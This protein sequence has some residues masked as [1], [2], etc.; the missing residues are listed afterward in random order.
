[1]MARI[2]IVDDEPQL[3][4]SLARA[5]SLEGHETGDA[6]DGRL[7]LAALDGGGYDLAIVDLSM[8]GMDGTEMLRR[9]VERGDKTPVIILTAHGTVERA[10]MALRNGA[11]DFLEKP[12]ARDRLVHAVER[13]LVHSR[14]SREVEDLRAEADTAGEMVGSGPLMDELR[15]RIRLAAPSDGRILITGENGTGKELVAHA[16]HRASP[17][18]ERPI[19]KVNCAAV[20]T[21]LFESELF[22]HVRGAFTDA[23]EN[24]PGCFERAH[25]GTLFLDEVGEVPLA[26][27]PKLLRAIEN[28]EIQRLGGRR[29]FRVDVRLVA[30]TNR[31]LEA[32][33]AAGRFRQDLFYRLNV[34][35]LHVPPLRDHPQDLP[36][37]A[38][39][40]LANCC[41]RNGY[42]G[43]ELTPGALARLGRHL[44]P[45]NVRELR[46]AMERLAILVP[47]RQIGL[48]DV[49]RILPEVMHGGAVS[50]SDDGTLRTKMA[51]AERELLAATLA[52]H[53]WR[54]AAAARELGMERSHLYKKVRAH[55]LKK[56]GD[57][58]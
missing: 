49:E 6:T 3:R 29:E 14:L 20:P 12:P 4:V 13:A 57:S 32:D 34:I 10:V 21:S 5:L 40:F 41:R 18:R 22:G 56:P 42:A 19:I 38:R 51:A 37:L 48:D 28:G 33:I 1:M 11:V 24:R 54:M 26:M 43:R 2:L 55:G 31:D 52:R 17:R 9:L 15:E 30:A 53:G 8:P 36:E 16:I 39:L 23:R 50:A 45:G 47:A 35:R 46:N 25:H 58:A 27:Q 7:G 44:W